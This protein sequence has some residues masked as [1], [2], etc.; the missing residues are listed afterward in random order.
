MTPFETFWQETDKDALAPADH[1]AAEAIAQAAW[2]HAL[3]AASACFLDR[4]QLRPAGQAQAAI[5]NLHTWV[6]PEP[7]L[8][9]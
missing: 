6:K 2:D 1:P 8:H 7:P 3:C 4:G 9:P 5:S